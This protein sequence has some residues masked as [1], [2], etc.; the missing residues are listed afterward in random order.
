MTLG[1]R[2]RN[3]ESIVVYRTILGGLGFLALLEVIISSYYRNRGIG[4]ESDMME[5]QPVVVSSYKM[6]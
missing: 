5:K 6:S 4:D 2:L 1:R 3:L